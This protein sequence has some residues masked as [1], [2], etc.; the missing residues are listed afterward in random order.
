MGKIGEKEEGCVEGIGVRG[1]GKEKEM[2]VVVYDIRVREEEEGQAGK[3]GR[4]VSAVGASVGGTAILTLAATYSCKIADLLSR[5]SC[6]LP[7][8]ARPFLNR[9]LMSHNL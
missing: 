2:V 7:V 3:T 4:V 6:C 8:S 1:I 9:L 5:S